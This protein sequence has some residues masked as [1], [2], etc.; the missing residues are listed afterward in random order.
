MELFAVHLVRPPTHALE[1]APHERSSEAAAADGERRKDRW[2][3]LSR[4]R[5]GVVRFTPPKP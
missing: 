1:A 3:D 5:L 4:K 2:A